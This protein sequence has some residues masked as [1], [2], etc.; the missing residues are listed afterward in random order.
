[1][2]TPRENYKHDYTTLK[3]VLRGA[4]CFHALHAL[5][6]AE[7]YHPGFRKGGQVPSSITR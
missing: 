4:R 7:K 5:K 1:M 2:P 6:F 3:H